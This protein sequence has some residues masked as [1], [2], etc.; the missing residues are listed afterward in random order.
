MRTGPTRRPLALPRMAV[1]AAL[2]LWV[3]TA[4]AVPRPALGADG[5]VTVH[6]GKLRLAALGY[7]VGTALGE[8]DAEFRRGLCA[9]R[10]L[11]GREAHRGPLTRAELLA[12]RATDGLPGAPE[13][14]GLTIDRTCQ[15]AYFREDGRWER[16]MASSTGRTGLPRPGPYRVQWKRAGW[17]TSSLYWAPEPNMYN[18][19][20]IR[21]AIAVHGS[22]DVPPRPASRG[23]ARLRIEDADWLFDRVRPGDAVEVVGTF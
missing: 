16:A 14:R 6:E 5:D 10:R 2:G 21:G 19:I 12:I 13:G 9:W 23:C 18:A 11:D 4:A 17:H 1:A 3:V 15:A 20:Y 8:D 22:R 7:P